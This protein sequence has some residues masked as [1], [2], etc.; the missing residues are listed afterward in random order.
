MFDVLDL[1]HELW[2]QLVG[3]CGKVRDGINECLSY[4]GSI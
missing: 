4:E 3:A 1:N 2:A